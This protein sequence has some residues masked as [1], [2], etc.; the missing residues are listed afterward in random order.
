MMDESLYKVEKI[1]RKKFDEHN[2]RW[3]YQIQWYGYDMNDATWEPEENLCYIPE[4]LEAFNKKWE[5][6]E[7]LLKKK[8]EERLEHLVNKKKNRLSKLRTERETFEL[9]RGIEEMVD[10]DEEESEEE[11]EKISG[12]EK[13][14]TG[15][16][17]GMKLENGDVG[18]DKVVKIIGMREVKGV[19]YAAVLFRSRG[20]MALNAGIIEAKSLKSVDLQVFTRFIQE[21]L[22]NRRL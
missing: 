7:S 4:M 19:A 17:E 13:K 15:V 22:K 10:L 14:G 8:K 12:R 9:T 16:F 21:K 11:E 1:R 5:A 2:R 18:K 3:L 20:G 6:K